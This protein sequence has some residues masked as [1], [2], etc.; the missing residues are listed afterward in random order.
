MS[1]HTVVIDQHQWFGARVARLALTWLASHAA[2]AW[3]MSAGAPS[4]NDA[5]A[6][7]AAS[8]YGRASNEWVV[9]YW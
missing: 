1:Q 4:P 5:R 2:S 3:I 8:R 9:V 7:L 6:S